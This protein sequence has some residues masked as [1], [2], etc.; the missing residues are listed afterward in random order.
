M[1]GN[2]SMTLNNLNFFDPSLDSCVHELLTASGNQNRIVLSVW[3]DMAAS[4]L[5]SARSDLKFALLGKATAGQD[6]PGGI[7]IVDRVS[8]GDTLL[9]N[10]LDPEALSDILMGYIDAQDLTILAPRTAH[11]FQNRPL[12]LISIPK[13]GTHLL[14]RLAEAIGYKPAVVHHG[15]PHPG[16]WYCVEYS[17]SHTVARDFFVDTVRRAPFG[18]RH[19]PFPRTP[20]LFIYRNPLDIVVSEANYY[21]RDGATVFSAYLRNMT[22]EQRLLRLIDDP[23]LLG[24]IRDRINNFVPWLDCENVIP[25]SFEELIG[26]KG[27]GNDAVRNQLIWSLQMKLHIPGSPEHIGAHIFSESSPTFHEGR[28]GASR[29]KM[30]DVAIGRFFGLNQDFMQLTGYAD[31]HVDASNVGR[32][33]TQINTI[34]A[35]AELFR[36]RPLRVSKEDWR[37]TPF[38]VEW[39]FLGH[40]I[41]R[42][43]GRY[44]AL[45][46]R[47]GPVDLV[48]LRSR[49]KLGQLLSAHDLEALK[50]QIVTGENLFKQLY[51]FIRARREM[52]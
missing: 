29:D 23:H 32:V 12:F 15:E 38:N 20:T 25:V 7:D 33:W 41:V 39:D 26:A 21:H 10:E 47:I 5:R 4:L 14:Y 46:Y 28:I 48:H 18:N 42:F 30:S 44:Y 22:F 51:R 9:A 52:S 37:D 45:P 2:T 17:N 40:N 1:N 49:G 24:S 34:P 36:G 8:P 27:G 31:A 43:N 16:N 13:G 35:K 19:H 50:A 3:N 6:R 11:Y